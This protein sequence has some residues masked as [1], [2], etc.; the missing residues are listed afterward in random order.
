VVFDVDE[1]VAV[2]VWVDWFSSW[3]LLWNVIFRES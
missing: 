2:R 1:L 3:A